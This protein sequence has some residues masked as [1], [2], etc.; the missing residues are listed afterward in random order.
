MIHTWAHRWQIPPQAITELQHLL[1]AV[2]QPTSLT[3]SPGSE[4]AVQNAVRME[5]ARRLGYR[6][7]RNN[8]GA[9]EVDG[10]MIR[11]GLCNE[12][13]KINAV[14]KSSDLIGIGPTGQFLAFEVK[15]SGWVY[16]GNEHERAQLAFITFINSMGGR[17]AFITS[18]EEL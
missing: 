6:L 18:P 15:R 12:S 2:T 4:A 13:A 14:V 7:W 5:A 17:A 9:G 3:A 11:W 8:S 16:R 1:G 10:R